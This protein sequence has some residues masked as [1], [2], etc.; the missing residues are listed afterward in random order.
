MEA[1]V[2]VG[3]LGWTLPDSLSALDTFRATL[4]IRVRVAMW[5]STHALCAHSA[6]TLHKEMVLTSVSEQKW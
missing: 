5:T 1:D 3:S 4:S 2:G 6:Q